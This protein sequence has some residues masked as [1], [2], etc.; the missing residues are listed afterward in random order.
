MKNFDTLKYFFE[1]IWNV[2]F[3]EYEIYYHGEVTDREKAAYTKMAVFFLGRFID[4]YDEKI[5][6]ASL[7]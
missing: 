7:K 1:K 4:C 3:F 5:L 2:D 6:N